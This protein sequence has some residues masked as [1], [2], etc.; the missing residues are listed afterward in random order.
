MA[1]EFKIVRLLNPAVVVNVS[2]N[3][4]GAYDNATQYEIGDLVE[5]LGAAYI[6]NNQTLG[7]LP[8]DTDFWQLLVD[9]PVDSVN[10]QTG[11]VVL[12]ADHIDD[13]ATTNKFATQAELDQINT[14]E[15]NI[16]QEII[17]R[18]AGDAAVQAFSIQRANH[19][20]TQ[21]ASTI[22][23]LAAV[24]TS[25]D[26]ADVGLGNVD[27][28]SD[29]DKPVSTAQQAA[30]DLKYNAS[31]PNGFETPAQLDARDTANRDRA[32][33]TGTQL[34]STVSDFNSAASAAAPIQS[35]ASKTGVVV[36]DKADVG[37]NNVDNTSDLDKPIS[38]ATQTAL[39]L[40]ENIFNPANESIFF[41]D[42]FIG[43]NTG[44]GWT[45]TA[46]GAGTSAVNGTY[47]IGPTNKPLGIQRLSTG[48]T[49]TG[50]LTLNRA[51]NGFVFGLCSVDQIWRF[52]LGQLSI[53]AQ[54]FVCY[55]GFHDLTG[56]G[57]P[58]EGAYF[59]YADSLGP[60]WLCITRDNNV[61]TAIDSGV[62]AN[63][64]YNKFRIVVN[65]AGTQIQ[66]FINNVLVGTSV[67]NIPNNVNRPTGIACRIE[68]ITGTTPKFLNI[69][70]YYHKL[71]ITGGRL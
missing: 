30:L 56:A 5:Y 10:G 4:R 29:L 70:Y 41:D 64:S 71:S 63:I 32:N 55:V 44:L 23:G 60:N 54:R 40:K 58:A 53:P 49:T 62:A 8:T 68:S 25:G 24:A 15:N 39:D 20:G 38:T 66:F 42:F 17:D 9:P 61:Q 36:L 27:N 51:V 34:A 6:A 19:T 11:D 35:V 12:D 7:N 31:N 1:D 57:A 59:V 69:D 2:I 67:T 37:L 13:T 43:L 26:K 52:A 21:D 45:V 3:P 50:R 48:T 33:H 16:T 46:A 65:E 47:G 22:T 28:T 14:N 18:V